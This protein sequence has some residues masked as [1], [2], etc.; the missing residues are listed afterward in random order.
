MMR[1]LFDVQAISVGELCRRIRA[2][3]RG[4]FPSS[5]RVLGE[6]SRSRTI[7]GNTYFTLKDR[8]GLIDCYCYRESAALLQ[9]KLPLEDGMAVEVAGF[10]D[11]YERRSAY[12]LRVTGIIPVGKGALY[13]A[14]EQLKAKLEA[15]GLF[16]ASRKR[17]IPRFIRDVAIVTSRNAAALQ[18][19]ITTCR[20]RGAHVQIWLQHAPVS[21]A[22]AA[23]ELARAILAAGRLPVDVVVVARGGGPIED[24]WAFNTEQ[25][26]RAIADCAKPVISAVGHETDFSIADFVADFRV[27][28]PTAAAELVAQERDAL[29]ARIASAQS[30]LRRA[31]LR[32]VLGPREALDRALRELQRGQASGLSVRAQRLDDCAA[33]LRRG[34][35]RRRIA[36]WQARTRDAGLRLRALASRALVGP[37]AQ[38]TALE[39]GLAQAFARS[40]VRR[41]RALDVAG[42]K[43]QALGPR[44]T[45]QRGYAIAYD[46]SGAVLTESTRV[47]IG[48]KI[49][50]ELKTGSLGAIVSE[51]KDDHG[52]NSREENGRDE[53]V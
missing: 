26:A 49:G 35:P 30:R 31:L 21:G 11:I 24:L 40:A 38:T 41:A 28:T 14:F 18:D 25:V 1:S 39:H 5:V 19:F 47:R 53:R 46:A 13:L 52:E 6:V 42:A 20:R 34:D 7:D 2:A 17:P 8:E 45:L 9:V 29:L 3:L 51:K 44:R 48:E 16:A 43:L 32:R 12:Q 10:V 27:P 15:E 23:P 37:S 22:A 50:V 4:G 33:D 36:A